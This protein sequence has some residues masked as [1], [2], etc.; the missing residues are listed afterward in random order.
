MSKLKELQD[1]IAINS[2]WYTSLSNNG[3]VMTFT[4]THNWR[5]SVIIL[6][7]LKTK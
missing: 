2:M 5:N 6:I 3:N 1:L 7:E 4:L